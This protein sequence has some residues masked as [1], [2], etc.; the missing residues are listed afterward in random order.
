NIVIQPLAKNEKAILFNS[1]ANKRDVS[2]SQI[3]AD[4]FLQKLPGIPEIVFNFVDLIKDESIDFAEK[5]IYIVIKSADEKIKLL[6]SQFKSKD[7]IDLLVL[8]SNFP[9]ITFKI[10]HEISRGIIDDVDEKLQ[11]LYCY[12]IIERY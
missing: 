8:L 7:Y 10:L 5:N 12:S 9:S 6:L 2:L 3:Q 11:D 1:Y 4:G